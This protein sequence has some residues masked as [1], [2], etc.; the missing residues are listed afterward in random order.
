MTTSA[1]PLCKNGMRVGPV[2]RSTRSFTPI[3]SATILAKA[4]VEARRLLVRVEVAPGRI[5]QVERNDQFAPLGDLVHRLR[6][7]WRQPR[8]RQQ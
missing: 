7:N 3:L 2:T 8:A 5:G 1:R 6:L 4:G